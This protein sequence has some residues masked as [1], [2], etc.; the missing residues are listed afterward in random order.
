[1]LP[2]RCLVALGGLLCD[3]ELSTFSISPCS[4]S[5]IPPL[6]LLFF[7]P[8]GVPPKLT[9]TAGLSAVSASRTPSSCSENHLGMQ[10]VRKGIRAIMSTGKPIAAMV[11]EMATVQATPRI[12]R[13]MKRPIFLRGTVLRGSCGSRKRLSDTRYRTL[14]NIPLASIEPHYTIISYGA[15]D[16]GIYRE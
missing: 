10:K 16:E 11:C 2:A 1:M 3:P 13:P 7:I 5:R 8:P 12:W 14:A 15:K 4:S 6:I 9:S